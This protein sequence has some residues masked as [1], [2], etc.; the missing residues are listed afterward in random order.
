MVLRQ[1][2]IAA[3]KGV[4]DDTVGFAA[5]EQR[6]RA[7]GEHHAVV[8]MRSASELDGREKPSSMGRSKRREFGGMY[9]SRT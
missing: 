2:L 6:H 5:D 7:P 1:R 3:L 9:A 4:P 8:L